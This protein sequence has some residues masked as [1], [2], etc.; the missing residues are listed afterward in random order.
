MESELPIICS[1]I[2]LPE[3]YCGC[4]WSNCW[5]RGSHGDPQITQVKTEGLSPKS[6]IKNLLLRTTSE[7]PIELECR[8][9]KLIFAW[10]LYLYVLDSLVWEGILKATKRQTRH[11]CNHENSSFSLSSCKMCWGNG[12]IEL[13]GGDNQCLV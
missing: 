5:M 1:Q 3:V 10:S 9:V 7:Q 11:Q 4:I 6:V 12:S 8:E 13:V 2:R